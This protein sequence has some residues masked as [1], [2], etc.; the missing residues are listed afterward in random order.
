MEAAKPAEDRKVAKKPPPEP[1]GFHRMFGRPTHQLT[2][3]AASSSVVRSPPPPNENHDS[4]SDR[5][6]AECAEEVANRADQELED[7]AKM[8]WDP[9]RRNADLANRKQ[10]WRITTQDQE[11]RQQ[12]DVAAPSKPT[13]HRKLATKPP[14]EPGGFQRL[15]AP[16]AR[17]GALHSGQ[18]FP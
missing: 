6:Q 15:F 17:N 1:G 9:D 13:A 16:Q 11:A 12:G 3:E 8:H 7:Q 5:A 18:E 10:Q 14:P 2:G 4:N